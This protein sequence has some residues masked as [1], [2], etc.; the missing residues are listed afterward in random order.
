M[1]SP[2]EQDLRQKTSQCHLLVSR[3]TWTSVFWV[4][5]SRSRS[6]IVNELCQGLA[7]FFKLSHLCTSCPIHRNLFPSPEATVH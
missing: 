6:W 1:D 3:R 2:A 7:R 5:V 4:Q